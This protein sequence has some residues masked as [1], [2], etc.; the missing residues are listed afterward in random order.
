MYYE[1]SE[2][3]REHLNLLLN[4]IFKENY[5][6]YYSYS[7]S[8]TKWDA[9]VYLFNENNE[10]YKLVLIEAKVRDR[11]YD[12]LM[13]EV[14]KFNSLQAISKDWNKENKKTFGNE[15][16]PIYV[17]YISITPIGSFVF[18]LTNKTE[19]DFEWKEE[20]HNKSTVFKGEGKELKKITYIPVSKAK[21][22]DIITDDKRLNPIK[23][24]I[25]NQK[26]NERVFYDVFGNPSKN[27]IIG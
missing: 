1:K 7:E 11:H 18:N 10:C 8:K 13:L 2:R 9:K 17:M 22:Y 15:T 25:D 3:E 5:K 20:M 19:K 6:V 27:S 12:D 4:V 23:P 24:I 26:R 21:Y 14:K 16:P